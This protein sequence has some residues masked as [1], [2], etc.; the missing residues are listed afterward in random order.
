MGPGAGPVP[1]LHGVR[2][3]EIAA[4]EEGG[5]EIAR[6]RPPLPDWAELD[7]HMAEAIPGLD[8]DSRDF[9]SKCEPQ[10]GPEI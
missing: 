8:E 9:T 3:L 2:R 10:T 1:L 7:R 5:T 6:F 4:V